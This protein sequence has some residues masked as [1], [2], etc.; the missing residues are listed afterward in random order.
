[1]TDVFN[2]LRQDVQKIGK[3]INKRRKRRQPI[4]DSIITSE[5]YNSIMY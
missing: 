3:T 2:E 1:M 4:P 5:M